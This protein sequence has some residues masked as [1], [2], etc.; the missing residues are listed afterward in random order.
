MKIFIS[1]PMQNKTDAE[2]LAERERAIKA[3]KAKWGDDVEALESFFQGAP[4]EAKPLW[5]L[6]ESLKV[7]ADAGAVIVCKG[8]SN[9]RGCKVEIVAAEAYKLPV[10]FMIGNK[11]YE[12]NE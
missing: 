6:G 4:A 12:F 1:Q 10:F 7:M 3:A 2:I 5:F 9:A 8:W 11:V